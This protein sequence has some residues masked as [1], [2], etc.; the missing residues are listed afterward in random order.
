MLQ[1]WQPRLGIEL[2]FPDLLLSSTIYGWILERVIVLD[3]VTQFPKNAPVL[4]LQ[5]KF[6][7]V[8]TP[9]SLATLEDRNDNCKRFCG[10]L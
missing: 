10:F 1:K 7:R 2:I 5:C 9:F 8:S 4:Q 6:H 3:D